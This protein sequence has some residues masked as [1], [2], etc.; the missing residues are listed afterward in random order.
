MVQI[1]GVGE[2]LLE[3]SRRAR[4]II[5]TVRPGKGVRVAMPHHTSIKSAL[6]FVRAK[7]SWV[8]KHMVTIR[9]YEK[10]KKAFS[11]AFLSIDKSE[12]RKQIILRLRQL[13]K[14]H[15]FTYN[16]VS[17]RNQRTRW[18]SC[19]SKGTISLNIKLVALPQELSDYV[20]LHELVHTRIHNHSKKFWKE[21]DK[22][23]GN[24][25]AKA[26]RL[27]EYGLGIL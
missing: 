5:I 13:A 9:E 24:G 27:I 22:Y 1:D 2:V 15:G 14:L 8:Q 20:M 11:D 7:K 25:K 4:R 23:V 18:G 19:S 17:I 3:H 6:E 12:A 16:K 26:K 10:R 21:L